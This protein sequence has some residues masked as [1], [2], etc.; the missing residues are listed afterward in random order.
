MFKKLGHISKP[1]RLI[2]AKEILTGYEILCKKSQKECISLA[3]VSPVRKAT[4]LKNITKLGRQH[5]LFCEAAE[6]M[7]FLRNS[8]S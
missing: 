3:S 4:L 5:N 1:E 2:L 6:C 7:V 8:F